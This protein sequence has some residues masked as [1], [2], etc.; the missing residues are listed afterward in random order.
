MI[1]PA[2]KAS[3]KTNEFIASTG[4]ANLPVDP[5]P[6]YTQFRAVQASAEPPSIVHPTPMPRACN[7]LSLYRPNSPIK[8]IYTLDPNLYI[9]SSLLPP[10]GRGESESNRKNLKL[11]SANGAIDV[12]IFLLGQ[13]PSRRTTMDVKSSNGSVHVKLNAPTNPR[14]PFHLFA[15]S[16]NGSVT[17]RLPRSFRGLLTTTAMHGSINISHGLTELLTTFSE[18]NSTRRCFVGDLS[19]WVED[20]QG[21]KGDEVAIDTKNGK[22]NVLY[23]DE[24]LTPSGTAKGFF[25]RVMFM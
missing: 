12:E 19:E 16:C 1:I 5:P 9:P 6:S 24:A 10:L 22:V 20:E 2:E 21:W 18:I 23:T 11:M 14:N 4:Q 13:G 7:Y 3:H 25:S 17:V 15:S 8:G